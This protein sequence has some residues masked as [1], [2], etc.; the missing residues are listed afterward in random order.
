MS[1]VFQEY[2]HTSLHPITLL[3]WLVMVGVVLSSSRSRAILAVMLV[4]LFMPHSQRLVVAGV[5]FSMLRLLMLF[6]WPRVLW[7]GEHRGFKPGKI[8][9]LVVLWTL[10]STGIYLLRV[11]PSGMAYALGV[12]FDRLTIFFFVRLL[13]RTREAVFLLTRQFAWIVIVFGS[14]MAYEWV[15]LYNPFSAL[16][17][18][19][20][21]PEIRDGR[22]RCQA[23]LPHPILAGTVGA[24]LLPVFIGAFR[25]R[26]EG[27][28]LFGSA[29]LFATI[30]VVTSGSSGPLLAWLTGLLGWGLWWVRRHTRAMMLGV[31]GML[32]VIHFVREK[33]V[34]SL[35]QKISSITGGTGYHRYHL[36]DAF[37]NNFSDWALLG[38]SNTASWGWGLR[39]VTNQYVGEGTRGGL[40]TLTLFLVLL[41]ACFSQLRL[42][43]ML[44]ERIGG[45]KSFWAFLA[46]GFSVSL[47]VHCV[48][49]ISVSYFGPMRSFLVF[50]LGS[51]PAMAQVRPPAARRQ[52]ATGRPSRPREIGPPPQVARPMG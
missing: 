39:D 35:I 43:R 3:F 9:K 51:I 2:G 41:S 47:A 27:R 1:G 28:R 26:K 44:Y 4:C 12:A 32:V 33:P 46:W 13:V 42:T 14:F 8:D 21:M 19:P 18:I 30:V 22:V 36:I 5:D 7:R 20:T 34:W 50:F 17:G 16:A 25:G 6:A 24:A 48:S 23:S 37:F 11:G 38:T 52:V 29:A 10:S 49:F 45:P 40:L 31:A 15:T